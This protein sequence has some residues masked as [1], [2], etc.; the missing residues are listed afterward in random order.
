MRSRLNRIAQ[1]LAKHRA[2]VLVV[3]FQYSS[4]GDPPREYTYTAAD[5]EKIRNAEQEAARTG[6][7]QTVFLTDYR[8]AD[9]PPPPP[10]E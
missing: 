5:R 7:R 8:P 6:N 10:L 4:P 1:A 2:G 3:L 9:W